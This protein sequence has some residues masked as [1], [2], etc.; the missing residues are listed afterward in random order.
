MNEIHP[1]NLTLAYLNADYISQNDFDFELLNWECTKLNTDNVILNPVEISNEVENSNKSSP[2]ISKT[3]VCLQCH[4]KFSRNYNL[5]QHGR[6]HSGEKLFDCKF[7]SKK[8]SQKGEFKIH[9]NN[10]HLDQK[11]FECR[12]CSSKFNKKGELNIHSRKHTG[13]KPC[14]CTTCNKAFSDPSSLTKHMRLHTN[15]KPY[16]CNICN[17]TF[18]DSSNLKSHVI[19][20][21][22][23][24]AKLY[25]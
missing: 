13:E 1:E 14:K 7:C 12:V 16:N 6:I 2:L 21:H 23:E 3:F 24:L 9:V 20:L 15:E 4:R 8:F 5:K 10:V 18:N 11:P 17:K 22:N 25:K 19:R